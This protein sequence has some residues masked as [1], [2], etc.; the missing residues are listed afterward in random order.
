MNSGKGHIPVLLRESLAMLA[1]KAGGRYL[2]GTVGLGGHARAILE[3]APLSGLCGMDR[4]AEALKIAGEVLSGFGDRVHLFRMPFSRFEDALDR[5]G[6]KSVDGAILDL[7]VSSLQLDSRQRGFSFLGD[8][9]L[10][11]RMDADSGTLSAW[12]IVNHYDFESLRNCLATLGEEPMAARIARQIVS[13]RQNSS[14]DTTAELC[15]IIMRAYPPAWRKKS[16]KHPATRTFQ[17]L[18]MEVNGELTELRSFLERIPDRL[19]VGGRLVIISFHSLEDRMVKRAM[20]GWASDVSCPPPDRFC[21]G[22][23]H[24]IVRILAKK[25]LTAADEELARNPRA[26]SAK[27][28]AVEKMLETDLNGPAG[29][30]QEV[31]E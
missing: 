19:S 21:A 13:A 27:L 24:P 31:S 4:D 30:N 9:R 5:L 15:G 23:A 7:G 6:W 29:G 16:R 18:R 3:A 20:R 14:I 12:D 28:R 8:A 2:D 1:P 17:A 22:R 10:D 26:S 11:M 25:P